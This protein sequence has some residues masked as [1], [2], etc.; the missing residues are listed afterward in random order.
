MAIVTAALPDTDARFFFKL[1]VGIAALIVTGFSLH[2]AMGRSSFA[3]PAVYHAHALVYMGW[4][5]IFV[6]QH[7]LAANGRIDHHRRLGR[8]ALGWV[9]LMVLFGVAITVTVI[10]RGMTPFFFLPQHFLVANLLTLFAFVGL[11]TTAIAK[12][13]QT[14]WHQR[15]HLCAMTMIL[16]PAFGRLLPAPLLIPYAFEITVLV[17]G[18]FPLIA[19]AREW[20][21]GAV[22]PAWKWG[23]PILPITL[24]AA[25][26]LGHSAMAGE[27]YAWVTAGT[28][29]ATVDPLAYG[30]LPPGM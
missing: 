30:A 20:R 14:D 25:S 19:I 23:L 11:L 15:L 12:R 9:A 1:A 3:Q 5:A 10:Q 22:H 28:P 18:I 26:L 29:G 6:A 13:K 27:I 7:W 8:L 2:F 4:V 24:L 21:R 16:G 17:G